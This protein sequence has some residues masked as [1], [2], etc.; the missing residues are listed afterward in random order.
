M[1]EGAVAAA[2]A[3]LLQ[4]CQ[5]ALTADELEVVQSQRDLL[6]ERQLVSPDIIRQLSFE[7]LVGVSGLSPGAAAALKKA[8]PSAAAGEL[9]HGCLYAGT[10]AADD[11]LEP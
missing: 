11:A 1:A 9:L 8:F 7:Q 3:R 6:V 2:V 4:A 10:A 5:D